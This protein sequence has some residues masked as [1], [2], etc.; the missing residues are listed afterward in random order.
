MCV[1]LIVSFFIK[2]AFTHIF[3]KLVSHGMYYWLCDRRILCQF[4][5]TKLK[6][7]QNTTDTTTAHDLSSCKILFL[8]FIVQI[9]SN[10]SVKNFQ[11]NCQTRRH[12]QSIQKN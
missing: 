12:V 6:E 8:W 5:D 7:K 10:T 4:N 1:S 2:V 9:Q 11:Y 3:E